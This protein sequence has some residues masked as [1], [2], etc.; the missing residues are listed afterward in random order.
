MRI[1]SL[2]NI[3]KHEDY[4]SSRPHAERVFLIWILLYINYELTTSN[5]LCKIIIL[6]FSFS[7]SVF[8]VLFSVAKGWTE[9]KKYGKISI[10]NDARKSGVDGEYLL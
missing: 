1:S 6:R 2:Y 10:R 4:L 3:A 7:F 8:E 5:R 9:T